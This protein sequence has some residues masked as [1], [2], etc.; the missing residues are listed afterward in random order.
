MI[1]YNRSEYPEL[2]KSKGYKIGVEIGVEYGEFANHI[3][4]NW[5]GNLVCVDYWEK[6]DDSIYNEPPNKKDFNEMFLKFNQNIKSF[7]DRVLI[8]KNKSTIASNFFPDEYFDFIYIDANHEY[9]SIKEDIDYWFPKLK[10][11][12]L[13]SGH[14]WIPNFTPKENKNMSMFYN[15]FYI[16]EYGVNSAVEEFCLNKNYQINV[17]SEDFATWYF[18]K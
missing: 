11:G 10:K 6:Q 9:K 4:K 1:M 5:E 13:F 16:G 18:Y 3:L 12:G 7:E 14:D 15:D 2:L 8:V 17:T